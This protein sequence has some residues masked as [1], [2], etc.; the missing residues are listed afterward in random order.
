MTS[1]PHT[2]HEYSHPR[3]HEGAR[4]Q[5]D[6]DRG[7][8]RTAHGKAPGPVD[9]QQALKGMDHP[10]GKSDVVQCVERSHADADMLDMLRKIPERNSRA[11]IRHAGIGFEGT[12][13]A[14]VSAVASR[15]A[16]LGAC[17]A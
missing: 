7:R 4:V 16:R 12:R 11:R 5:Q 1:R 9:V 6:H 15:R 3:T 13:A 14:D 17:G 8:R 2:G 10:A